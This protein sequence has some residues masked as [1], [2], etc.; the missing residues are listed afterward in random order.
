[1]RRFARGTSL[2]LTRPTEPLG[3][4][5][6]HCQQWAFRDL[7]WANCSANNFG[8]SILGLVASIVL[9][10]ALLVL[11]HRHTH[12]EEQDAGHRRHGSSRCPLILG[13]AWGLGRLAAR[14]IGG[15]ADCVRGWCECPFRR[16][17]VL[18]MLAECARRVDLVPA[19]GH[20]CWARWQG[21]AFRLAAGADGSHRSQVMDQIEGFPLYRR[22][23]CGPDQRL[24]HGGKTPEFVERFL[25]CLSARCGERGPSVSPGC[26]AAAG[27]GADGRLWY[28]GNEIATND[29]V[30]SPIHLG[31]QSF[32]THRI[33]IDPA[34]LR[35][36]GR[37]AR[38]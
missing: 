23:R 13:G 29:T 15:A 3:K 12:P 9:L 38:Q 17:G 20:S 32:A 22:C 35:A 25:R 36:T 1:M 18:V 26:W 8:W 28:E 5:G 19:A 27:A 31:G 33:G 2:T 4:R 11:A 7:F 6:G 24:N 34:R 10:V 21:L 14:T 16:V 30:A 37:R